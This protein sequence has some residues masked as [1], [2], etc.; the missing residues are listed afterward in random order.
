MKNT[1]GTYEIELSSASSANYSFK[2]VPATLT[3]NKRPID[4]KKITGGIP[5]LTSKMIYDNPQLVYKIDGIAIN[6]SGQVEYENLS[7][8]DTVKIGYTVMYTSTISS[9]NVLVNIYDIKID[10]TYGE[11]NNYVLR[12]VPVQP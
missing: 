9:D 1:I 11:G 12:D 7:Y 5:E 10:D 6:T 2:L 3:I 4:V 8:G